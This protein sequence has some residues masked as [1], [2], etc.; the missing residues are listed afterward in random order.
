M[1]SA[2]QG[3]QGESSIPSQLSKCANRSGSRQNILSAPHRIHDPPCHL[4][5][6][7]QLNPDFVYANWAHIG[8]LLGTGF[9]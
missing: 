7:P 1:A 6:S 5:L 2:S 4:A 9:G 8:L 3:R